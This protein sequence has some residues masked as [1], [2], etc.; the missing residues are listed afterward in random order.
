MGKSGHFRIPGNALIQK[1]WLQMWSAPLPKQFLIFASG[2]FTVFLPCG[3]LYGFVLGAAAAGSATRGG[4]FMFV[5]W[6]ST[7]PAL[8]FGTR[9]LQLWLGHRSKRLAGAILIVAGIYSLATFASHL[10]DFNSI[11]HHNH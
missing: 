3:H 6:L 10:H 2:L 1:V 4:L 9:F 7:V 8:G 11:H 5:F